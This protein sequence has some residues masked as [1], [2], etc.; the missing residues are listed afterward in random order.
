MVSIFSLRR[1]QGER[2]DDSAI[3]AP[4]SANYY[5][6]KDYDSSRTWLEPYFLQKKRAHSEK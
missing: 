5:Q 6:I 1:E 2:L 3:L 4:P